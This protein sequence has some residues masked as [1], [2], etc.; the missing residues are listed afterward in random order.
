MTHTHNYSIR[1]SWRPV[2]SSHPELAWPCCAVGEKLNEEEE[3]GEGD[4]KDEGHSAK[5][6]LAGH[7]TPPTYHILR[8]VDDP[9][10]QQDAHMHMR[11]GVHALTHTHTHRLTSKHTR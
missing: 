9:V 3:R 6:Q 11:A 8:C 4:Q 10:M 7:N 2:R 5:Q 1:K